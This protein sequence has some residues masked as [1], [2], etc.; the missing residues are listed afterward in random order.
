MYVPKGR[1]TPEAR[2]LM[3][4]DVARVHE[5][6]ERR[7]YAQ[8]KA[9]ALK[10]RGGLDLAGVASPHV[11]WL[12]AVLSDDLGEQEEAFR[13]ITEATA[14]DPLEPGI[15]RSFDIIT[16]RIRRAL[17]DPERDLADESTPRLHGMLVQAGKADEL[18][19]IAMGRHLAEVGK[20]D[21]ALALLDAVVL[22]SPGFRD[23]WVA[24]AIVAKSLG[25]H[26]EAAVA[27]AQTIACEGG[28][29]MPFLF[30]IA[31][32]AVA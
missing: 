10:V 5:H 7:E 28:G 32:K 25:R 17:I 3:V 4:A 11:C 19:H 29:Q 24:K 8:G 2:K 18:A 13:Y 30:G 22:L 12:L 26:E 16:D 6:G 23:G 20:G 9:L 15:I 31:S 21:E 27:H 1:L 14:L